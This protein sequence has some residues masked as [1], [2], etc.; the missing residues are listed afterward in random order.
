MIYRKEAYTEAYIQHNEEL[1]V[2]EIINYTEVVVY[3]FGIKIAES[4]SIITQELEDEIVSEEST[5]ELKA[6]TKI[7]FKG[8]G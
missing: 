5:G 8:N 7:G 3:L 2:D 4:I 1:D 6:K